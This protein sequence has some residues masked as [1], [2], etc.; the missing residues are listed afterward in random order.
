MSILSGLQYP[1]WLI[2]AG[3]VLVVLGL[4]GSVFRRNENVTADDKPT[5]INADGK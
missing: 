4:A 5:E 2:V 3:T 1:H